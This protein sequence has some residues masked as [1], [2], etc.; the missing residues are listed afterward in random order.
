VPIMT[1]LVTEMNP[2]ADLPESQER[3][4]VVSARSLQTVVFS[5]VQTFERWS[6]DE[7]HHALQALL[8]RCEQPLPPHPLIPTPLRVRSILPPRHELTWAASHLSSPKPRSCKAVRVC[9]RVAILLTRSRRLLKTDL[10]SA[11]PEEVSSRA[12]CGLHAQLQ[13]CLSG[14]QWACARAPSESASE[15]VKV[16]L[17][18]D[19]APSPD[20]FPFDPLTG[21]FL[22][23]CFPILTRPRS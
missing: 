8:L 23:M 20:L 22:S 10:L 17:L 4:V 3:W 18:C 2:S 5:H 15:K 7:Q 19:P 21:R 11:L 9:Y 16:K 6:R 13:R 12:S 1:Q 14:V